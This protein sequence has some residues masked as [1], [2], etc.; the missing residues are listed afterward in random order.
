M[1]TDM[2]KWILSSLGFILYL[3]GATALDA[4]FEIEKELGS[5]SVR[6]KLDRHP[7]R[8]GDNSIEIELRD[9][10]GKPVTDVKVLVHYYMPP[11]PRMAPMNYKTEAKLKS[12]KYGA[13]MNFV[14]SGPWVI[15]I[16]ITQGEKTWTTKLNV[17]VP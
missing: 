4:G 8:L 11:M 13:T 7:P 16:R 6:V 17:D 5:Y 2:K 1:P 10:A 15:V 3:V 14:M 12:I 9:R